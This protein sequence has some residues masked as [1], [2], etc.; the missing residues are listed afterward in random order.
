MHLRLEKNGSD[1]RTDG[2]TLDCNITLTARRDQRKNTQKHVPRK[3]QLWTGQNN[4][5]QKMFTSWRSC[6]VGAGPR[7][8]KFSV[9]IGQP[10]LT[11]G[12]FYYSLKTN[13]CRDSSI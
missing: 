4:H 5:P 2:R 7:L 13:F 3:N 10:D 9:H 12:Q 6:N 1:I 8:W 11:L